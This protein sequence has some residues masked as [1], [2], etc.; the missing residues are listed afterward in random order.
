MPL[1]L[2]VGRPGTGKTI[3]LVRRLMDA[4]T[5]GRDLYANFLLGTRVDGYIVPTCP[6][7]VG[8]GTPDPDDW[9]RSQRYGLVLEPVPC[10]GPGHLTHDP[11]TGHFVAWDAEYERRAGAR[12][13]RAGVGFLPDS[14][15]TVLEEW[16]QVIAIRVAR[17]AFGSAH[18]LKLQLNPER[19]DET[20]DAPKWIAL[21]TCK[22]YDCPGCSEGV[23]IGLDELNLWAPSRLW[24]EMGIDVLNR[25]AYIRKDGLDIYATA[26]HEGRVDVVARQVTNDIYTCNVMGGVFHMLGRDVHLQLFTRQRWEPA[27][28]TERNR[29]GGG[30]GAQHRSPMG[31]MDY[32]FSLWRSMAAAARS[33]DTYEHVRPS[34]HLNKKTADSART[35][36]SEQRQRIGAHLLGK[37]DKKRA[38]TC[39]V[40]Q[41]QLSG[42]VTGDDERT[43]DEVQIPA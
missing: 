40:C 26:Q 41:V 37:H 17:D 7:I 20:P 4:R 28:L 24:Q 32:D 22:V 38:A 39:Y 14:K 2:F 16:E 25:W 3:E 15:L 42:A 33:Y 43:T 23:T 5:L 10:L 35:V 13:L 31:V 34:E 6:V 18:K 29:R 36:T 21:P 11:V 19:T 12:K 27:M 1:T 30:E 9:L 8:V